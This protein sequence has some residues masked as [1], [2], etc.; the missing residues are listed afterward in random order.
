VVPFH[1]TLVMSSKQRILSSSGGHG[2][3]RGSSDEVKSSIIFH[4]SDSEED[5]QILSS[6]PSNGSPQR[7]YYVP[8][9][10]EEQYEKMEKSYNQA[11]TA[12]IILAVLLTAALAYIGYRLFKD[13]KAK[14]SDSEK[15]T[16]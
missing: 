6:R 13:R 9:L 3:S 4:N 14:N 8:D 12:S 11:F 15:V 5:G 1:V 16:F 7:Q 2:G 10:S